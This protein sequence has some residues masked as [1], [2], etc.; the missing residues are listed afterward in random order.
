MIN[1]ILGIVWLEIEC[2]PHK[3]ASEITKLLK[4]STIGIGSGP[5]CGG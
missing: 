3:V 4:V 5:G 2:M 1:N